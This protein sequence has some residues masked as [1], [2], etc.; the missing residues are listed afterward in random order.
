MKEVEIT[1]NERKNKPFF[2]RTYDCLTLFK[3]T[4]PGLTVK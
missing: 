1:Q 3:I 4:K 2:V